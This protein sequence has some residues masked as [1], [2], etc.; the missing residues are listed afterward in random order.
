MIVVDSSAL[1]AILL[2]EPDAERFETAIASNECLMSAAT[3]A[4]MLI[5]ALGKGVYIQAQDI[6]ASVDPTIVDLTESRAR[7]AAE[8]YGRYG[9][10]FHP[11]ALN[12]GDSFAYAL[13]RERDLPLLFKG[14]DFAKTDVKVA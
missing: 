14:D 12:L 3:V 4:E 1:V 10:G 2:D 6:I 11:A 9:K 8:A 13:A 7:A 5:V